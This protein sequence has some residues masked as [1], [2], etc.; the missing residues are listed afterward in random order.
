MLFL[1]P[2]HHNIPKLLIGSTA[3]SIKFQELSSE[4]QANPAT[5][6]PPYILYRPVIA[7]QDYRESRLPRQSR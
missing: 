1:R 5:F 6:P 4:L 3:S 7:H 2:L